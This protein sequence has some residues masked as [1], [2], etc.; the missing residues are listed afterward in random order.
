MFT[1]FSNIHVISV[2]VVCLE[3]VYHQGSSTTGSLQQYVY[4]ASVIL[5]CVFELF[6]HKYRSICFQ[7]NPADRF[8]LMPIITPAYPQQNS[9]FNVTMSTRDVMLDEF[10]E[11]QFKYWL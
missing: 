3:F 4:V 11:G 6:Y 7:V 9:T 2:C 8:H 10:R 1:L 5:C